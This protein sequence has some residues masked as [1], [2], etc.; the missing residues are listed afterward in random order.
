[1]KPRPEVGLVAMT[2][3]TAGMAIGLAARGV[4][5]LQWILVAGI[6]GIFLWTFLRA[7]R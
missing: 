1:V 6:V 4:S 5:A 3:L 7:T 2:A